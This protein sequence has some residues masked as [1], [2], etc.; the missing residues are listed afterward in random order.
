MR[1]RNLEMVFKTAL[2][3]AGFLAVSGCGFSCGGDDCAK[4][5]TVSDEDRRARGAAEPLLAAANLRRCDAFCSGQIPGKA[6]A[7]VGV[8]VVTRCDPNAAPGPAPVTVTCI[9]ETYASVERVVVDA[10]G[11]TAG[12]RVELERELPTLDGYLPTTSNPRD[13]G[14]EPGHPC[15]AA[16]AGVPAAARWQNT[17]FDGIRF[18]CQLSGDDIV[19]NYFGM[20]EDE[21]AGRRPPGLVPP[22]AGAEGADAEG[23]YWA[24]TAYLEAAS[25]AAFRQLAEELE[26]HGAPRSLVRRARAAV[27]DEQ[28]HARLCRREAE[29]RGCRPARP[30]IRKQALRDLL[31]IGV[32]NAVE[33]CVKETY[34]ALALL[35]RAKVASVPREAALF[36]SI[37]R[38]ETRHAQLSW[39]LDAWIRTRLTTEAVERLD[40]A[41]SEALACLASNPAPA[42]GLADAFV[43][44]LR[45]AA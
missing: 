28:R 31:A 32:D 17:D 30:K 4:A 19:C 41:R 24:R 35:Y 8:A 43:R 1:R 34:A 40:E 10:A 12:S 29:R 22:S 15:Q 25:V 13:G 11:L 21:G 6:D 16:C 26:H 33:G 5:P 38:D 9:V 37:A 20:C 7:G 45:D 14:E 42:P 23:L 44:V 18:S 3:S 36:T 27:K 2:A 39:D